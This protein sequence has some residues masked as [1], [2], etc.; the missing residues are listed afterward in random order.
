MPH[1]HPHRDLPRWAEWLVLKIAPWRRRNIVAGDF[2]EVFRYVAEEEGR[3][4]ALKWYARQVMRSLP[5]FLLDGFAFGTAMFT[6]YLKIALRN[7]RKRAFFSV[8]NIGG[9][10]L[11]MAACLL[12]FQYVIFENSYDTFHEEAED[13]YRVTREPFRQGVSQG[14]TS[15]TSWGLAPLLQEAMPE[16]QQVWRVH[17]NYGQAT[18]TYTPPGGDRLAIQDDDVAFVEP[19]FLDVFSFPVLQ[20]DGS[21]PLAAPNTAVITRSL[22]EKLL[23][24]RDPVGEVLEVYA[25]V[26]GSYTITA[27]IDDM[28]ANGH[29]QFSLLLPM[30]DLLQT[31]Q[32][33]DDS[34]WGWTNFQ[35]YA[36]LAPNTDHVAVAEK[37]MALVNTHNT[38][39]YARSQIRMGVGL[40][41]ITDIHLSND[42]LY[43]RDLNQLY[44][45][46]VIALFILVIAWVNYINLSTAR[47][48]ERA[49][50]VGVRKAAGA[51]RS[52]LINQFIVE[53][54][55]INGLGLVFALGLAR[56]GLPVLNDLAQTQIDASIWQEPLLWLTFIG[57]FT[58]GAVLAS[59]YPAAILS[60]FKPVE[61]LKGRAVSTPGGVWLRRGLVVF[62]FAA[63]MALLTGTYIVYQQVS[64]MRD[65]DL[66]V[67]LTQTLVIS[68][69]SLT[70]N[71][72]D[73]ASAMNALTEE[74]RRLSAVDDIAISTLAPGEGYNFYSVVRR[75]DQPSTESVRMRLVSVNG[76]FDEVYGLQIV[77]GRGFEEES[78]TD[79]HQLVLLNETSVEA[80]GFASP[81]DAIDQH[82][83]IGL[84]QRSRVVGVYEDFHWSSVK[85]EIVPILL[86]YTPSGARYS[87]RL[88]TDDVRTVVADVENLY[89]TLFPGSPF[90]YYFADTKFNE[91][92][93][94][95]ARFGA[96]FGWFAMLALLVACLGLVGLAAYTAALRTKEIGIRKVLGAGVPSIVRLLT[97]DFARLV[98]IAI[99]LVVPGLYW[100]ADY[101]LQDFAMRIELNIWLFLMPGLAVLTF[102]LLTVSYHTLRTAWADPARSLR[103][104]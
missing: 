94:E 33:A 103:A 63:S 38:E 2:A 69:P 27:V 41:P 92:Y 49:K 65:A 39:R 85:E 52:Q 50:E 76:R 93:R 97:T 64:F 6:N 46:T 3:S 24:G 74:L 26:N 43:G 71:D 7:L 56:L 13:I 44:F 34:G 19:A 58:I 96:L 62:Q 61:V 80:M 98:V 82:V 45:F 72:M 55:L 5:S 104:E 81:A 67:D 18:L 14:V 10:A 20:T 79:V 42:V 21:R 87:I 35:T 53:S 99:I 40:Q 9:L 29:L 28:P 101:W 83:I 30:I 89:A 22:A 54:V 77:A 90:N 84:G 59:L 11:G 1:R 51:R 73:D 66:G 36:Q 47:A 102:A 32:Y 57:V 4:A 12:I 31:D 23:P 95:D 8:L 78:G 88:Q 70:P 48:L 16:M 37:A 60:R 100:A 25:W 17:P 15:N 75:E 68:H 86:G 91:Q